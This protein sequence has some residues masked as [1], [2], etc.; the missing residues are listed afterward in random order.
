MQCNGSGLIQEALIRVARNIRGF[1]RLHRWLGVGR[2]K[3]RNAR[4]LVI[5]LDPCEYIDGSIIRNG[6]Y[7]EE[8]LDSLL[9]LVR[10]NDVIWDIGSNT[11]VHS[12]TTMALRPKSKVYLLSPTAAYT[13]SLR[14]K[15]QTICFQH[16]EYACCFVRS[17]RQRRTLFCPGNS[18]MSNLTDWPCSAKHGITVKLERAE[19]LAEAVLAPYPN[20]KKSMLRRTN[21]LT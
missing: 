16:Y 20:I 12:M 19:F 7:E 5:A 15:K 10:H 14:G 18:G 6:Y 17:A 9:S 21:Y 2:I 8:V 11:G 3:W 1:N 4:G 13:M